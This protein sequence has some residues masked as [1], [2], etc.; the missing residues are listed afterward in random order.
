MEVRERAPA[1]HAAHLQELGDHEEDHEGER[2]AEQ[3][4]AEVVEA[5]ALE[6]VQQPEDQAVQREAQDDDRGEQTGARQESSSEA[7]P[8]QPGP[9]RTLDVKQID[10]GERGPS[11]TPL[12]SPFSNSAKS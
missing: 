12:R 9:A 1:D 8:A 3:R 10:C 4:Q 2:V 7:E 11:V 5:G 6:A